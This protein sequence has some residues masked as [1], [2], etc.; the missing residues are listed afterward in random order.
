MGWGLPRKGVGIEEFAPSLKSFR[1]PLE[2]QGKQT[3]SREVL[4]LLPGCP[5]YPWGC[6]K[7]LC[8]NCLCSF[9]GSCLNAY[10]QKNLIIESD[11]IT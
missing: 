9:F 2:A 11:I 3:L 5:P 4:A 10:R 1:P 7:G 6:S 8:I